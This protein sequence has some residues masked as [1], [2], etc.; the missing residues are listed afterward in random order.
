M[1]RAERP[2]APPEPQPAD[3]SALA[4][5]AA[6][7]RVRLC[8]APR[9]SGWRPGARWARDR[10][11]AARQVA[12]LP[13]HQRPPM[14][15]MGRR[16]EAAE[17]PFRRLPADDGAAAA[18]RPA[19]IGT[20]PA[21]AAPIVVAA[22]TGSRVAIAAACPAA[23]ALGLVPGMALTQARAAVPGIDVRD[24]DPAGDRAD[25]ARLAIALA[26]RWCPQVALDGAVDAGDGAPTDGLGAGGTAGLLLDISGTAHL[27]GGEAAMAARLLRLFARMGIAARLAIADTAGA[28]WALARFDARA[29]AILCPPGAQADAIAA[30]PCDAL[31][32]AAP[33]LERLR[34]LGIETVGELAAIPRAPLVRRFGR[35]IVGRLD[36]AT[37]AAP[38]PLDPVATPVP[39]VVTRRFA[40]PIQTAEAIG[41]WLGGL[42]RELAAAL[43]KAGC[44]ARAVALAATRVDG[45]VQPIRI[46]L[47]RA[48]RDA[49]HLARLAARRIETIDPGYG[50]EVLALHVLRSEPL[51][52]EP[53]T[54]DLAAPDA[55]A[56]DLAP[57]V[58]TLSGRIG[59]ARLWR[60]APCESDVPERSV[61][62]QPTLDPPAAPPARLRAD[63]VRRL[64][65]RQPPHPWH[66]R[67][68]R[69]ARLLARP[70]PIDH[71]IAELPDQP[72]RRFTWRGTT[73]RVV[74]GDGPERITGEWWRRAGERE[75]VRD[76][77][78]VEDEAGRRF[79]LFRRG[80]GE[81][82]GT[83]DLSWYVHGTF[84]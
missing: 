38:E 32:L 4:A 67:W 60:S 6:G 33:E 50:I 27:H 52:A 57:L 29:G 56:P 1:R 73:H 70:E 14:R 59:A 37:G 84:G 55:V 41:H 13:V 74:C 19:A 30:L 51:D 3:L 26:R 23:L 34:R 48:T 15:E 8:D 80:D 82:A 47:A 25:L 21:A 11:E 77:F 76:Y 9:D 63:D 69:P 79:W 54:G 17:M 18:A 64:D 35:A 28:A 62:R 66:P 42:S 83:G 71:V 7:E 75:A 61:T 10:A 22:R 2:H 46:G 20:A 36:A 40:E 58:D 31:R 45:S 39:I 49:A 44:G 53:V 72:P 81:R 68:P 5:A 43:A 24:A 12:A 78:R 16:S 65:G